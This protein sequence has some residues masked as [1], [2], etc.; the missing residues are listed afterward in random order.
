MNTPTIAAGFDDQDTRPEVQRWSELIDGYWRRFETPLPVL[1]RQVR[2]A[3]GPVPHR[4][5]L[6]RRTRHANI[7]HYLLSR[8]RM[9]AAKAIKFRN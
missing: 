9:P 1:L 5:T 6:L 7:N 8:R 3:F 2:H 4:L